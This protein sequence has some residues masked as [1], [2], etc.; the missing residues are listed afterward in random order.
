MDSILLE[1]M[2]PSVLKIKWGWSMVKMAFLLRYCKTFTHIINRSFDPGFVPHEMKTAKVVLINKS[3]DWSQLKNYRP[4]SILQDLSE[5]LEWL[6][7]FL[8]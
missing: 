2:L 5:I 1:L 7:P 6:I 3:A 8:K 4:A